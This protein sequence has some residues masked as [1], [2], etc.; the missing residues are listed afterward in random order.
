M[1]DNNPQPPDQPPQDNPPTNAKMHWQFINPLA[2]FNPLPQPLHVELHGFPPAPD[3]PA[4][5]A[6]PFEV[7]MAQ[8]KKTGWDR[9]MALLT[10]LL[11]PLTLAIL[12]SI[13]PSCLSQDQQ[14]ET[15]FESYLNNMSTLLANSGLR[16]V[17]QTGDD[18]RSIARGQ[19]LT[20]LRD[21]DSDGQRKAYVLGFLRDAGLINRD[22]PSGQVAPVV[23]LAGADLRGAKL[24]KANLGGADLAA[25]DL[26]GADLTGA[27]L[28][29]AYL[30]QTILQGANLN[31]AELDF[32]PLTY[33]DLTGADLTGAS[34][35]GADLTGAQLAGANFSNTDATGTTFPVGFKRPSGTY[36][37]LW[38]VF[39]ENNTLQVSHVNGSLLS[40]Y[41]T[42]DLNTSRLQLLYN[43]QGPF[44][45]SVV[46]LP[47][48]WTTSCQGGPYCETG[49]VTSYQVPQ[50]QQDLSNPKLSIP[51]TGT[52]AGL[53]VHIALTF[54]KNT[55]SSF[56]VTVD[57]NIPP[58]P[59]HV[60]LSTQDS[61][62]NT[63]VDEAFKPVLL[64]SNFVSPK[65]GTAQ[66]AVFGQQSEDLLQIMNSQK[67]ANRTL[68]MSVLTTFSLVGGKSNPLT[69]P[70]VKVTLNSLT[71]RGNDLTAQARV[72]AQVQPTT[73]ATAENVDMWVGIDGIVPD[74]W[75]Y[76]VDV[77]A[78]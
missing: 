57:A 13:I 30:S 43:P 56:S 61:S 4:P 74:A 27:D 42:L 14:R 67:P 72:V 46:L 51:I 36:T 50:G 1:E 33:A 44:G 12:A 55:N 26:S 77:S 70:T 15:Q 31:G 29:A 65:Q 11:L 78:P 25:A 19:T 32:A 28:R 2:N 20:V 76:T 68:P 9:A 7:K 47:A 18:L 10:V 48:L 6:G 71:A 16:L 35:S 3:P 23:S 63:L 69:Y 62:G 39:V 21:L 60:V 58:G 75:N 5:L 34:L 53:T 73:S 41:A 38:H 17:G 45:T 8:Q 54:S 22:A 49:P 40:T 66:R 52:V 59:N 37:T 64:H 24:H